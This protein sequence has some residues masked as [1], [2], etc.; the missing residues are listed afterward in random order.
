KFGAT[1]PPDCTCGNPSQPEKLD[2]LF[3]GGNIA[4]KIR[5]HFGNISWGYRTLLLPAKYAYLV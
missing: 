1:D 4:R 2:H 5:E 3:F